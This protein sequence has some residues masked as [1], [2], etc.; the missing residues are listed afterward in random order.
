MW[1]TMWGGRMS[2]GIL[3]IYGF[4][5]SLFS[6][7]RSNWENRK[8]GYFSDFKFQSRSADGMQGTESG[9]FGGGVNERI[10]GGRA[11]SHF[12]SRVP[13]VSVG[14]SSR[15]RGPQIRQAQN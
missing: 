9:E 1:Q 3:R 12:L 14:P 5:F 2:E 10:G 4:A 8:T 6:L 7:I 13:E 11:R 15:D